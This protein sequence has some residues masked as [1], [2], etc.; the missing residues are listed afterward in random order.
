MFLRIARWIPA[1]G[2]AFVVLVVLAS[3]I[4]DA[5]A[6][7]A[8]DAEIVSYYEDSD[9]RSSELVAFF[10]IGLAAL[11]F[12]S[13]LGSLRGALARAEGEPSRLTAATIASGSVFIALAV[14]AHVAATSVTWAVQAHEEFEVDPDTARLMLSVWYGFFV[15]SLF[16]A[17]AMTL[18]ASVLALHSRVFP[19]WLALLGFLAAVCG[20]LGFL[21]IPALVILLWILAVSIYL[22]WPAAQRPVRGSGPVEG[23]RGNREVPPTTH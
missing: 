4:K 17:A 8:S 2:I 22:L 1:N 23:V 3:L 16:A 13:F 9:N 15:M 19:T 11:C 12:L 18:A 20:L 21:V 14:A 10:L 5:P 7:D 6:I